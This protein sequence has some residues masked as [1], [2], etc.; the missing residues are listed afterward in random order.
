MLIF[1]FAVYVYIKALSA[2]QKIYYIID[3]CSTNSAIDHPT[4]ALILIPLLLIT[5]IARLYL[6]RNYLKTQSTHGYYIPIILSAVVFVGW[7]SFFRLFS[8]KTVHLKTIFLDS[9]SNPNLATT[10]DIADKLSLV[11]IAQYNKD[12]GEYVLPWAYIYLHST[13]FKCYMV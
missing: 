4:S 12:A 6:F 13:I 3:G 10:V 9:Y 5:E 8:E 11:E 1:I 2:N 7:V